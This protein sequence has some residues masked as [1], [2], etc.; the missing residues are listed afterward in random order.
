MT[1]ITPCGNC[2]GQL[3]SPNVNIHPKSQTLK[4]IGLLSKLWAILLIENSSTATYI[5]GAPKW[6]PNLSS[7][8]NSYSQKRPHPSWVSPIGKQ[9]SLGVSVLGFPYR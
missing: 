9:H 2:S 1:P 8:Q 6:D 5:P 3:E 7:R 4:T